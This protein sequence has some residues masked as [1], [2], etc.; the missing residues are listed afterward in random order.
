MKSFRREISASENKYPELIKDAEED[1]EGLP[2]RP[3]VTP[4]MQKVFTSNNSGFG[5]FK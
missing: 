5:R 3:S 4:G 2:R 1:G